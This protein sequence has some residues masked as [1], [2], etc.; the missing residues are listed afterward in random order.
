MPGKKQRPARLGEK[1]R[2]VRERFGY[3]YA[4]MAEKV[5]NDDAWIHRNQ[6]YRYEAG[7]SDPPIL[8]LWRYSLLAKIKME[9]FA[10]D[11][12]NLPY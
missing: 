3:S 1:L 12:R 8:I 10:D 7:L 4:E 2:A 6:V 9:I 11:E 5:S